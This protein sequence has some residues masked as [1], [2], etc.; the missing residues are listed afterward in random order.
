MTISSSR[1]RLAAPSEKTK[2]FNEPGYLLSALLMIVVFAP[3]GA[4]MVVGLPWHELKPGL[5]TIL[6]GLYMVAVGCMFLASFHF[7]HKSFFLRGLMWICERASVPGVRYMAVV[8]ATG[9]FVFGAVVLMIGL[10]A[11]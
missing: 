8:Y 1:P 9:F 7:D 6:L 5:G 10:G 3:L 4:A 11:F 2:T